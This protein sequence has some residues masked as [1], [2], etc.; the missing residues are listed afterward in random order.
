MIKEE[1]KATKSNN[2]K[3]HSGKITIFRNHRKEI[4]LVFLVFLN[5]IFALETFLYFFTKHIFLKTL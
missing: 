3:Q 5:L 4:L 2:Y 1:E